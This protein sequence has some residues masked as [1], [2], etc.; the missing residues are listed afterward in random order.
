MITIFLFKRNHIFIFKKTKFQK[1]NVRSTKILI[2]KIHQLNRIISKR[3]N[4][5]SE[6]RGEM[7]ASY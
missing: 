5:S 1:F 2:L 6:A 7:E 4:Y 3:K